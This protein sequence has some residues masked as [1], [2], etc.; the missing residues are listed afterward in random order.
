MVRTMI[1]ELQDTTNAKIVQCMVDAPEPAQD[2]P[3]M[4]ISMSL[5]GSHPE[6]EAAVAAEALI[7]Y[8]VMQAHWQPLSVLRPAGTVPL[9][10]FVTWYVDHVRMPQCY[11]S[12]IVWLGPDVHDWARE[13]RNAWADVTI[14]EEPLHFH[15]VQPE[16]PEKAAYVAAHIILTQQALPGFRSVL[17]SVYDSNSPTIM[18][19]QFA[20][21]APHLL[22]WSTLMDL[23]N[24]DRDCQRPRV[25]CAA[26]VG[27][28]QLMINQP[29]PILNGHSVVVSVQRQIAPAPPIDNVWDECTHEPG[30]TPTTE[31]SNWPKRSKLKVPIS[32]DLSLPS[33]NETPE[34]ELNDS[35]P[36]L[37][38][39]ER[40]AWLLKLQEEPHCDFMPL[41]EGFIVPK[42]CCVP[43]RP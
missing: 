32:I 4:A 20:A 19:S 33:Q 8:G 41:P 34:D 39:F 14:V 7:F 21:R 1:Q 26:W 11:L 27:H 3:E 30:N 28:Q 2:P 23:A 25:D 9:V 22:L 10:P 42:R 35:L 18:Q 5:P 24:R 31:T 38:W 15:V 17:L 16:V 13:M 40:E 43:H 6:P 37:L 12:R 29:L 36:H